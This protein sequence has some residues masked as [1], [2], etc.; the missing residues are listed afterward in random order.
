[1]SGCLGAG[2]EPDRAAGPQ[3]PSE[4]QWM[5]L[6]DDPAGDAMEWTEATGAGFGEMA[7]RASM[8]TYGAC[9]AAVETLAE[10][11]PEDVIGVP[12]DPGLDLLGLEVQETPDALRVAFIVAGVD[13]TFSSTVP[14]DVVVAPSARWAACWGEEQSCVMLWVLRQGGTLNAQP[15]FRRAGPDCMSGGSSCAWTVPML[16]EPGSPG[17]IVIEVPRAAMLDPDVGAELGA[18]SAVSVRGMRG[19]E[20]ATSYAETP[21][22]AHWGV[23]PRRYYYVVDEMGDMQHVTLGLRFQ[24]PPSMDDGSHNDPPG[25]VSAPGRYGPEDVDDLDIESIDLVETP[26]E[27][28]I[29]TQLRRV[30]AHKQDFHLD[31]VLRIANGPFVIYG[32]TDEGHGRVPY[33]LACEGECEEYARIPVEMSIE[34]GAP[35]WMNLTFGRLDLGSP[36][37]G[38]RVDLVWVR[39]LGYF[40][41][42]SL[43]DLPVPVY[44]DWKVGAN[45]DW[46]TP[47]PLQYL[48]LDTA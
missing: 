16:I 34:P 29:A 44:G 25:D 26:S 32:I 28:T 11:V 10:A 33:A 19:G 38:A 24:M 20:F 6:G 15:Q 8:Q 12:A 43:P 17:R 47:L 2:V 3:E 45:D 31:G 35:G 5:R 7:C 9:R 18:W 22:A 39:T 1:M 13:E 21:A 46:S 42:V 41:H 37:A 14:D 40:Q 23:Q 27:V 48:S 30:D 36:S 4:S